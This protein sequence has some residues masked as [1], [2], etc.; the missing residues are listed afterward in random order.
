M[1]DIK[2]KLKGHESFVLREGWLTKGLNAVQQDS[3]TFRANSGADVLGVGTNMAKSIRYWFR[4]LGLTTES[5]KNG[6][7]LTALG[8]AICDSDIYIEDIFTLWIL[9]ANLV[10]NFEFATSWA[11]FFNRLALVSDFTREEMVDRMKYSIAE[12][13]QDENLSERSIKDDCAAILSMYVKTGD[14]ADDP[15]DKRTSPF[16]DLGLLVQSGK[17]YRKERPSR[18]SLDKMAFLYLI[19]DRLN[20]ENSLQID[21]IADDDNMP[22]K[23]FNLTRIA[24]NDYLDQLKRAN[25]IKIDRTAGLDI[26]YPDSC[27]DMTRIDVVR[28][29]YDGRRQA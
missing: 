6:V 10:C 29:Y 23:T 16:E 8:D 21:T 24:I 4:A 9:H 12:Y 22:G 2:I 13:A 1:S 15:E 25:Y 28:S 26:V 27:M 7:S 11:V 14:P 20:N 5:Q 17:K 18:L 3:M 19:I